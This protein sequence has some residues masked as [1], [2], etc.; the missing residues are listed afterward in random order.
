M[1]DLKNKI[2]ENES[3]KETLKG[4]LQTIEPFVTGVYST[5]FN[6]QTNY[7]YD[8][9]INVVDIHELD[10]DIQNQYLILYCRSYGKKLKRP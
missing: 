6:G 4:V 1:S 9:P 5:L 2:L 7:N 8:S 10:P 3:S